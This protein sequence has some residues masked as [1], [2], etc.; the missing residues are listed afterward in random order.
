MR[1]AHSFVLTIYKQQAP[2]LQISSFMPSLHLTHPPAYLSLSHD[3]I[4]PLP[5]TR[6]LVSGVS[7]YWLRA[8]IN[9]QNKKNEY[10]EIY[11]IILYFLDYSCSTVLYCIDLAANGIDRKGGS[12]ARSIA[13]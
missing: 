9:T 8:Y 10:R 6:E 11:Y 5:H 4:I 1:R 12:L 3:S 2:P 7:T 13:V